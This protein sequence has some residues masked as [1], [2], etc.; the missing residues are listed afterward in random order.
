MRAVAE[1]LHDM[2]N[3]ILP[4][5]IVLIGPCPGWPLTSVGFLLGVLDGFVVRRR[6]CGLEVAYY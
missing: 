3:S 4:C 5:R 1:V 2:I 6:P